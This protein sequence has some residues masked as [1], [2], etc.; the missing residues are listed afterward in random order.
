MRSFLLST[1]EAIEGLAE[2]T[3]RWDSICSDAGILIRASSIIVHVECCN[4]HFFETGAHPHFREA[5][6]APLSGEGGER[7]GGTARALQK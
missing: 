3:V 5:R 2:L 1:N 4:A 7:V 6:I